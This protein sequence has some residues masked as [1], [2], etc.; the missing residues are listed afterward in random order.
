M[1]IS[2][3]LPTALFILN[4]LPFSLH[5]LWFKKKFQ[6]NTTHGQATGLYRK[7]VKVC[8]FGGDKPDMCLISDFVSQTLTPKIK[9]K[10]KNASSILNKI[11]FNDLINEDF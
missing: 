9:K 5:P 7:V 2:A 1:K 6:Q 10:T 11:S 4:Y 8:T 3:V